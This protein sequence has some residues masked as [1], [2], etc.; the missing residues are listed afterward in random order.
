MPNKEII[1]ALCLWAAWRGPSLAFAI[2]TILLVCEARRPRPAFLFPRADPVRRRVFYVVRSSPT[3]PFP[4]CLVDS[5]PSSETASSLTFPGG[6][7]PISLP[8]TGADHFPKFTRA[9]DYLNRVRTLVAIMD[10]CTPRTCPE[11]LR[12]LKNG[13]PVR[14]G[15]DQ[16]AAHP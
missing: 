10:R 3:N 4:A 2:L 8:D 13:R 11:V 14:R 15:D 7:A 16:R 5:H 6:P 1:Q 9:V 12:Q